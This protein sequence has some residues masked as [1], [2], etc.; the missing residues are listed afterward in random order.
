VEAGKLSIRAAASQRGVAKSTVAACIQGAKERHAAHED[1]Q[2]LSPAEEAEV[3]GVCQRMEHR[4]LPVRMTHVI[5]CAEA[6]LKN[7]LQTKDVHLGQHWGEC[8]M[9]R[10]PELKLTTSKRI[11]E[12]R[13]MAK[14]PSYIMEFYV[15]VSIDLFKK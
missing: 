1:D 6:I 3:V 14:N 12:R 10:H 15:L 13:V 11:D 8:F 4:F 5:G 7:R 9:K 2:S